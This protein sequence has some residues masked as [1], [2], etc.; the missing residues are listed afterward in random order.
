MSVLSIPDPQSSVPPMIRNP[1]GNDQPFTDPFPVFHYAL[2]LAR[3]PSFNLD[4]VGVFVSDIF[5]Q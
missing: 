3:S 1:F 4:R 5:D 2:I